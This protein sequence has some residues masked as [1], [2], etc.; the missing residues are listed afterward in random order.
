MRR[1]LGWMVEQLDEPQ[2][3]PAC[4]NAHY[5]CRHARELGY[6]VMLSGTGGDDVFSASLEGAVWMLY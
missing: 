6:K 5:I 4:L 2:A 3:D 1:D